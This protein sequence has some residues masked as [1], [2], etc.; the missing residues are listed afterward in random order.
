MKVT[1]DIHD[2]VGGLLMAAAGLFFALYG[3][4]YDMGTSARM[5][6]GYFPVVLG[7]TLTVLGILVALPAWWRQGSAIVVQWGN[8]FWCVAAI[9]LFAISLYP[10][11]VVVA[12]FLAALI[13][14][15][16][17]AEMGLRTRLTV[18]ATVALLTTLIFPIGLQMVL[19]IWPWSL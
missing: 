9:A 17:S 7:W 5:G 4:Q 16:P 18:C 1:R 15:V 13:S 8:L 2:I 11:G 10:L 19:P 14:L 6:P 12:S 3:G